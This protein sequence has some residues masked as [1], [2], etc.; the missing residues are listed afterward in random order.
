[1]DVCIPIRWLL[2]FSSVGYA[3]AFGVFQD[4]YT[5]RGSNSSSAISWIGSIQAFL[6]I[7]MAM[8]TGWIVDLGYA[9]HS[10]I[11]GSVVYFVW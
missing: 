10:I 4:Y 5:R 1:M 7:G 3:N 9:R 11:G 2:T 6:M 8:P